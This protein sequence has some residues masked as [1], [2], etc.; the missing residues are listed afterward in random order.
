MANSPAISF[1]LTQEVQEEL[2]R[3][4]ES[5]GLNPTEY[6]RMLI[7]LD[8]STKIKGLTK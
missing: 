1:R 3:Q 6:I 8:M 2:K 4:A 7:K 5:I